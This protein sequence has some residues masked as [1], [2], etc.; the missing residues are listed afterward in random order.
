MRPIRF[1]AALQYSVN[2]LQI[3]GKSRGS[4]MRRR[5]RSFRWEGAKRGE[6]GRKDPHKSN[7]SR[8]AHAEGICGSFQHF[9]IAPK[10]TKS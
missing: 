1:V 7:R 2:I 5:K 9:R 10:F 4:K 3:S 8:S 6:A